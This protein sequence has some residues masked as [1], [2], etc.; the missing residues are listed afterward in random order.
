MWHKRFES[1]ANNDSL[2]ECSQVLLLPSLCQEATVQHVVVSP[3]PSDRVANFSVSENDGV[4]Y[5]GTRV[6]QEV[7]PRPAARRLPPNP[8]GWA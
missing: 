2:V 5:L 1:V 3:S 6:S 4:L 7:F 8:A